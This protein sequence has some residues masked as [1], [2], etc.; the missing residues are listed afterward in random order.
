MIQRFKLDSANSGQG[1]M[2]G[3]SEEGNELSG[4]VKGREFFY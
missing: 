1:P 2:V 4:S 3:S